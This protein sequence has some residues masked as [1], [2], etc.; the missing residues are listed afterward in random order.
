MFYSDPLWTETHLGVLLGA[1]QGVHPD[2]EVGEP[3]ALPLLGA[4]QLQR[5]GVRGAHDHGGVHARQVHLPLLPHHREPGVLRGERGQDTVLNS[6]T[7]TRA[8]NETEQSFTVPEEDPFYAM[9]SP[10]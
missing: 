8:V 4:R 3:R 9:P 2:G 7:V 1:V 5:G 6:V 10:F